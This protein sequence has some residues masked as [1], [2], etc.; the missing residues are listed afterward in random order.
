[1]L[2]GRAL[3]G[4]GRREGE[5]RERGREKEIDPNYSTVIDGREYMPHASILSVAHCSNVFFSLEPTSLNVLQ[6]SAT[7]SSQ[8]TSRFHCC[9]MLFGCVFCFSKASV[10]WIYFSS[11]FFR[12]T[13]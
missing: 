13:E 10:S 11:N 4:R 9:F 12:N 8:C 1:V 2:S 3:A 5:E 7:I 6:S